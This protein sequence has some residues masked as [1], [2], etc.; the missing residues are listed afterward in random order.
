MGLLG[1]MRRKRQA[2]KAANAAAAKE[3][4]AALAARKAREARDAAFARAKASDAG[5]PAEAVMDELGPGAVEALCEA[6]GIA[7]ASADALVMCHTMGVA[8]MGYIS[9]TEFEAGMVSLAAS[10]LDDLAVAIS[11]RKA[12]L[13]ASTSGFAALYEYAFAFAKEEPR[14]K[15]VDLASACA[16]LELVMS[17]RSESD[18]KRTDAF[19]AFLTS[20]SC[21]ARA[22]NHD[23]WSSWLDFIDEIAPDL[24]NWED[25]GPYPVLFSEYVAH[26]S[27]GE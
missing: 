5:T 14:K 17:M 26:A 3:V 2:T 21:T 25:D 18:R 24:S 27:R 6:I 19:V 22:L 10:S 23:Q 16:M 12:Q 4:E 7:P 20:D 13:A 15:I 8:R 1:R 9:K 11:R